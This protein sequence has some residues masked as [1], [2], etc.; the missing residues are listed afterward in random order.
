MKRL[1]KHMFLL[2]LALAFNSGL[3]SQMELKNYILAGSAMFLSGMTDGTIESINY[4]YEDG[5]K[6]RCPGANDQFWNPALS[7]KN[8]YKNND[9]AQGPKFVGSTNVFVFT[10][11]AYHLLRTTNRGLDGFSIAYYINESCP[12]FRSKKRKWLIVAR[13]F[14]ALALIRSAGFHL[15]YSILFRKQ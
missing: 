9:P 14:V 7:W 10:T 2:V 3:R 4:H 1:R 15:T 8:K 5:F 11:D 6:L 13:D 12:E